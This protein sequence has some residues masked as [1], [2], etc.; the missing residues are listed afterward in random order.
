MFIVLPFW[1]YIWPKW[2]IYWKIVVSR[3]SALYKIN[4]SD[5]QKKAVVHYITATQL[6]NI[7][8]VWTHI[9]VEYLDGNGNR[10]YNDPYDYYRSIDY[11]NS[12]AIG[13]TYKRLYRHSE[14]IAVITLEG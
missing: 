10:S 8:D 11:P 4:Q 6:Y 12:L 2:W 3:K 1:F 9:V 14:A 7:N 5:G 13:D